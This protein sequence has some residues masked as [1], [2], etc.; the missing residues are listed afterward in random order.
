MVLDGS[1]EPS[2]LARA[3]QQVTARH[4]L[5]RTTFV[6]DSRLKFPWQSVSDDTAPRTRTIELVGEDAQQR[7]DALERLWRQASSVA[8]DLERGPLLDVTVARLEPDR[9]ALILTMPP[10]I[11]DG[12]T[13]VRLVDELARAYA[14]APAL[15]DEPIQYSQFAAWQNEQCEAEA[16]PS[17]R[18]SPTPRLPFEAELSSEGALESVYERELP[19]E[20]AD[21]LVARCA[22]EGELPA[23]LLAAYQVQ[24]ARLLD[25][26]EFDLALLCAGRDDAD[27]QEVLGP[28]AA[29]LSTGCRVDLHERVTKL[30]ASCAAVWSEVEVDATLS[31]GE[32]CEEALVGSLGFGFEALPR[33]QRLGG[34]CFTLARVGWGATGL[35]LTMLVQRSENGL[36]LSYLYDPRRFTAAGVATMADQYG[37]LLTAFA[38]GVD[39]PSGKLPL[40]SAEQRAAR[41]RQGG[42]REREAILELSL[43]QRFEQWAERTP[44]AL[45]LVAGQEQLAFEALNR[46]ANQLAHR[47]RRHGVRQALPVGLWCDR[48][49]DAVVGVLAILKAGG[50]YVPLDPQAPPRRLE[51][52]LASVGVRLLVTPSA[53][54]EPELLTSCMRISLSDPTLADEQRGNLP[55]SPPLDALASVIFTSGST[56]M[57]KGVAVTHRNIASY[58][59]ALLRAFELESGL[60]FATVSTMT[61]DLGNT[62]IFAA[63]ASGG[64][65][66]VIDYETA[67]DGHRFAAYQQRSPIDVLKIVPSH[68]SALLD[69]GE[70]AAVLPRKLVVLGG[71]AL[72]LSLAERIHALAPHCQAANHYGPTE[73]T[74]GALVLPLRR[75]EDTLGCA[76]VPLGQP[77]SHA[78]AYVLDDHGEPTATGVI[79]ELYLG[80][81]GLACGYVGQP[82]STAARFVPHPF[83]DGQRLYRTGDRARYRPDGTVEF[84]GRRDHQL[85]IRGFRVELGEVEARMAECPEVAQAVVLASESHGQTTLAAFVKPADA[86]F[87]EPSL[88][89]FLKERLP[90][91]M[92]PGELVVVQT[93]PLTANGKVD[94]RA[95]PSLLARRPRRAQVAPRNPT[96]A[97]IAAIWAELLRLPSVGVEDDFFA[98]G[99]NSLLAIPIVHRIRQA[100]GGT[101]SLR[102]LFEAPTVAGLARL[103]ER[104]SARSGALELRAGRGAAPLFCIDPTGNHAQAYGALAAALPEGQAVY[105]LELGPVLAEGAPSLAS[106]VRQ[107]MARVRE[108]QPVGPYQLAGWS[109]GGVLAVALARELE[110]QGERVALLALIDSQA[111]AGLYGSGTPDAIAELSAYVDPVQRAELRN[112]SASVHAQLRSELGDLDDGAR[113]E[114]A[115]HWAQERGYLPADAPV[116]AYVQ[117]YALLREAA[118]FV[119][120]LAS[121]G[122]AAELTLFWSEETLRQHGAAPV[123]WERYTRG[124]ASSTTLPGDHFAA[125][126]SALLHRAIRARLC[127]V[128]Q[129][130]ACSLE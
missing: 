84:L 14:D 15:V 56:G 33:A 116:A 12:Y 130:S 110:T 8:F 28:V 121:G 87:S 86:E 107:L 78:E 96:E 128:A 60:H 61:A 68:L 29:W 114:R 76:S 49:A 13:C 127:G 41:I 39:A 9:S 11:A 35:K 67:T 83:A 126:G 95:L 94:R 113:I 117:R 129:R 52:Q 93:L 58:T 37:A 66:H 17:A 103:C 19:G 23:L 38:R 59:E 40:A 71:E 50:A 73:T 81:R 123:S 74:V 3:L 43:Q 79:G 111:R 91:Y 82:A 48:S 63:L 1:F 32:G 62:S 118:S 119:D 92:I 18:P 100:L 125:L 25:R 105:A 124:G 69:A 101:L 102:A 24:L 16:A 108:L 85:K 51:A 22:R 53:I 112:L 46:R 88:R 47:L 44:E 120:S 98:L 34:L 6:S 70:G 75:F 72:P 77:L 65:L 80:G 30:W 55:E 5:L 99:G 4:E 104:E 27:V 115:V 10:L 26:S 109:L 36:R 2:R 97:A 89:A 21:A 57:P 31:L 7:R 106:I 122:L 45:A 42:A 64:C 90:D 54:T 20:L